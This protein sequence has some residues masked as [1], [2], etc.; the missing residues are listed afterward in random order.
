MT[1]Y[2]LAILIVRMLDARTVFDASSH[3][4]WSNTAHFCM[5][6]HPRM[7]LTLRNQVIV[8]ARYLFSKCS[9]DSDTNG[10]GIAPPC[11]FSHTSR[12][13]LANWTEWWLLAL[14]LAKTNTGE[15]A[16]Q[17][18]RWSG[19]CVHHWGHRPPTPLHFLPQ[20][21]TLYNSTGRYYIPRIW[22]HTP[23]RDNYLQKL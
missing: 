15:M 19:W 20:T 23:L 6:V 14:G 4:E 16:I 18:T 9:P 8:G 17:T 1:R 10:I 5:D 2:L 7:H 12:Q 22:L 11:A 21:T 13:A 3:R